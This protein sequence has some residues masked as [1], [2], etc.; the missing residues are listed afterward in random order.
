MNIAEKIM[1]LDDIVDEIRKHSPDLNYLGE[2]NSYER[3]LIDMAESAIVDLINYRSEGPNSNS[4]ELGI[5]QD[6]PKGKFK[7]R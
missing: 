7:N 6:W 4:V 3:A 1:H 5:Q 2:E